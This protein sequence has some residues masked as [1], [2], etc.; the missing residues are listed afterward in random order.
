MRIKVYSFEA[1]CRMV[2]AGV[3][4]AVL[5]ESS[6][7]RHQRTMGLAVIELDEPWRVRERSVLVRD[8]QALPT[9]TRALINN[10]L[11]HHKSA[12]PQT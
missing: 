1:M 7:R 11:A 4:L 12:E 5:P 3:G 2:E 8:L 9:V 6:A 10:L